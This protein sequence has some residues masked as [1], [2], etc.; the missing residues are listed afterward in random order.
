MKNFSVAELALYAAASAL[1]WWL[2]YVAVM[3]APIFRCG[4]GPDSPTGCSAGIVPYMIGLVAAAFYGYLVWLTVR[5][6][7]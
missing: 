4:L 3:L 2:V 6:A 5:N 1:Y 7:K